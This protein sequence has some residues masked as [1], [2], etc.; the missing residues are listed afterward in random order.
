MD[1]LYSNRQKIYLPKK[2]TILYELLT[3]VSHVGIYPFMLLLL[4]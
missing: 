3:H 2:K 1:K 4:K